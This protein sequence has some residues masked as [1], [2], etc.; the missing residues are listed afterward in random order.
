MATISL[1]GLDLSFLKANP[2][3]KR[4]VKRQRLPVKR[5][6]L[7][8]PMVMGDTNLVPYDRGTFGSRTTPTM[9]PR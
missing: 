1:T 7:A 4:T 5:S 6:H 8:A 3:P 9:S 2:L